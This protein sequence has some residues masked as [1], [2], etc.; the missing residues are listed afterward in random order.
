LSVHR[1]CVLGLGYIGLPTASTFATH[2][3][4][5]IGVDV[6]PHVVETL[7]EGNLHIQEPGLRTLV[8][9]AIRSGNLVIARQPEPADAFI[10]AVPTPF[11]DDKRADLSYVISAAESIVPHLKT[12]D[13]VILES[14]SPPLTTAKIVAPILERS[15]LKA[16]VDFFLAYSPERV[17]PGQ[18]LRELVENARVIGGINLASAQE[19]RA[20]Y[21][22]FVRGQIFV[23]DSTTA[24]MVKLI[25][26][27]YR[28][29][30]IA[31]ANEFS[32]LADRFGVDVWEA[33]AIANHHPRVR[34]LNPGPGVGGHCISV[35]P[36]F[37]VEAAPDITPLI[38]TARM[39][40]DA[41]P[42]FVLDLVR[43]AVG[44]DLAG[45]RVA[46]LGLSYK[47]DVDDLRES[48]AIEVAHLLVE[49]G[50]QVWAFEPCKPEAV[51]EGLTTVATLEAA[52]R[53]SEVLLL[54]IGHSVFRGLDPQA[55]A[56][57][58]QARVVID[59]INGWPADDWQAAGFK[60]YRLGV[61]G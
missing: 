31:I 5:V 27:T 24:E 19:G 57:M 32:R 61:G 18:I 42:H 52:L 13:L 37:L 21:S 6:N 50:C 10:I 26:N 16:G 3:L 30:N 4:Q 29:V 7:R 8:Q 2:G 1:I 47:P 39:V 48:P 28:D 51:I 58:T 54:L 43:K 17:L 41:Q 35:D 25:E 56:Q 34:I 11:Y 53:D 45:K 14:T 59:T 22:I 46:A 38:R 44:N 12:G 36:W 40:N 15:G 49:A 33:I 60:V 55:V 23:T 9:A 20:L